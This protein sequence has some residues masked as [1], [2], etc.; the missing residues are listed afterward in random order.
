MATVCKPKRKE[1]KSGEGGLQMCGTCMCSM[2]RAWE[3]CASGVGM[4]TPL[5][6][7]SVYYDKLRCIRIDFSLEFS[8]S[9][10]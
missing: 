2:C 1:K 3:K 9:D 8:E 7:K 5:W 4:F 10:R 6:N